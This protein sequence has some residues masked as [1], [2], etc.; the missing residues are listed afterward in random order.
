MNITKKYFPVI[1]ML[2]ATLV[3]GSCGVEKQNYISKKHDETPKLVVG[4]VVDQM[5]YD[6]LYKYWDH[7]TEGG[8]KRLMNEGFSFDNAHFDYAPT[9][10]GP[11]HASVYSGTTPAVHGIIGNS[12]FLKDTGERAYVTGD[13]NV[14]TVG[15]SSKRGKMSPRWMLSTSIS[16]ELVLQSN[17]RSKAVG[18]A[19]KDRASILPAGHKGEAYWYDR[20]ENKMITSTFYRDNLPDWMN[21]FNDRDLPAV[22]VSKPWNTLLPIE[23]YKESIEDDNPYEG[24]F[25]GQEVPAFPHDLPAYADKA[26][27]SIFTSTPFGNTYTFELAYATLEGEKLGQGEHTDLLAVSFS[28]TDAVGHRFAPASKELQD[29]YLRFDKDLAQFLSYLDREYGKENVLVFLTADHGGA[30]NPQYLAD[31]GLPTGS[32]NRKKIEKMLKKELKAMYG[33]NPVRTLRSTQLFLDNDAITEKGVRPEQVQKDAADLMISVEG[34][35]GALTADAL[36][37]GSFEDPI[38]QRMQKGYNPSRSGDVIYWVEP[39]WFTSSRS[40]GTTHGTPWSYDS[41]API[42]WYGW[43]IPHGNSTQPVGI[44]DIASTVANFLNIP[45]TTGNIG[46]PMNDIIYGKN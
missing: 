19:I 36:R 14:Y 42:V 11:G 30:H 18:I 23:Q 26:G 24:T 3:I 44:A 45:Y 1:F 41:R 35:A 43:N 31:E 4:I 32:L 15:S 38:H 5:R 20:D 10:T 8:I 39:Q 46:Q 29:T 13:P 28:S 22:Y 27:N 33:F 21:E 9:F 2:L 16:D 6:Y 40:R 17:N 7:Y 25:R 37:G 34:V 12:W